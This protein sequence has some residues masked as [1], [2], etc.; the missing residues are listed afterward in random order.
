MGSGSGSN[1][2]TADAAPASWHVIETLVIDTKT[3]VAINSHTSLTNGVAYQLQVSGTFIC[4]FGGDMADSEYFWDQYGQHDM[5]Q[6]V[7]VGLAVD[8]VVV[9]GTK[10]PRWGNATSNH[11][12]LVSYTGHGAPLKAVL[13]DSQYDNNSGSLELQ[14]LAR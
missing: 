12:Y 11:V 3:N 7:D 2:A 6:G 1:T 5:S 10:W 13:F 9:S 8:D 14:I 4:T